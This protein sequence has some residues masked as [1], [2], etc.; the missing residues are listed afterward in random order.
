M[1]TKISSSIP[2]NELVKF[3]S[4]V[5][6]TVF[7]NIYDSE[8]WFLKTAISVNECLCVYPASQF[9]LKLGN[10]CFKNDLANRYSSH[11]SDFICAYELKI[12]IIGCQ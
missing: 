11:S 6:N 8:H 5:A 4:L 12:E 10:I 9:G 7:R 3:D 1:I 2:D